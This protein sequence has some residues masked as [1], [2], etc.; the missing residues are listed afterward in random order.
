MED[1][2][3]SFCGTGTSFID[4]LIDGREEKSGLK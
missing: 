2:Q 4:A 1:D 3:G